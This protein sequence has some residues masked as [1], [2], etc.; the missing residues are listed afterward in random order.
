MTVAESKEFNLE[1]Y[2]LYAVL[3]AAQSVHIYMEKSGLHYH[4][5]SLL[6]LYSTYL[7]KYTSYSLYPNLC[8]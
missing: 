5:I 1:M 6:F 2:N 3:I 8:T 4:K 7:I